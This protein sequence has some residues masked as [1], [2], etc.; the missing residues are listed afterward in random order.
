MSIAYS[1]ASD[2]AGSFE[3]N[4]Q[5]GKLVVNKDDTY[6]YTLTELGRQ[7]VIF[8]T[9]LGQNAVS[10]GTNSSDDMQIKP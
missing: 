10:N 6:T 1:S 2:T 8:G 5:Y 7:R 9:N 3:I 4:G